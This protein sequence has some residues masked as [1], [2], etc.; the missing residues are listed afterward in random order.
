MSLQPKEPENPAGREARQTYLVFA[1]A[2]IGDTSLDYSTL[3]ERFA[4]NDWAAIKLDDAVS[5]SALKAGYAPKEVVKFLYQSPY[6]QHQIHQKQVNVKV[7][8][9][10]AASTVVNASQNLQASELLRAQRRSSRKK[11][12]QQIE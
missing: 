6:I 4:A 8:N 3:Y 2:V 12:Q 5:Q 1:R 11:R 7:M 9:Q 10:Y